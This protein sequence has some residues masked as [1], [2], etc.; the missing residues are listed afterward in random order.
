MTTLLYSSLVFLLFHAARAR[1]VPCSEAFDA[2]IKK[3]SVVPVAAA[4]VPGAAGCSTCGTL[5]SRAG[6]KFLPKHTKIKNDGLEKAD[7]IRSNHGKQ[8]IQGGACRI[9]H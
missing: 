3:R 5:A 4:T 8:S 6:A 7:L 2:L 9:D 1:K